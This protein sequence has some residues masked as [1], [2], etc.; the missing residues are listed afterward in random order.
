[1]IIYKAFRI[2]I[3]TIILFNFA[4]YSWSKSLKFV[5]WTTDITLNQD[6]TILVS[7]TLTGEFTGEFDYIRH[8]IPLENAKKIS[9]IKVYYE[10]GKQFEQDLV[11]IKYDNRKVRLRIKLYAK[12][13]KKRWTIEYKV[14]GNISFLKNYNQ[15]QWL[16]IPQDSTFT[17]EKVTAMVSLP[18]KVDKNK[19]DPELKFRKGIKNFRFVD[20][21][22]IE[23]WGEN[24]VPYE[25]F[26][27]IL[28]FP[29]GI[30]H[31]DRLPAILPFLWFMI[32]LFAFATQFIKWW[33]V[34]RNPIKR[35]PVIF[36]NEPSDDISPAEIAVLMGKDLKYKYISSTIVDLAQ[37]GYINVM[38]REKMT[39]SHIY[40]D[41][42]L[43]KNK[44]IDNSLKNHEIIILSAIFC[45][46]EN[47]I[48]SDVK[49]KINSIKSAV[50][51]AIV[52]Q[53]VKYEYL[54]I[55]PNKFRKI[56]RNISLFMF[57]FGAFLLPLSKFAIISFGLAGLI[58]VL[59]S[60]YISVKTLK[61]IDA[62]WRSAG[63]TKF[64]KF[65][66]RFHLRYVG[67][68]LF[69]EYLSYAIA[70]G[71]EREWANRFADIYNE[72]PKWYTPLDEFNIDTIIRFINALEIELV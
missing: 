41:Y 8:N 24:I 36:R 16:V 4:S 38:E 49:D 67:T 32:P 44:T 39:V 31:K 29:K 7:E 65:N 18:L 55:D 71:I 11:E 35:R 22:T 3:L 6:S 26:T 48:L 45:S 62:E 2:F 40:L 72:P 53:L 37:R 27:I 20:D 58:I 66:E 25:S 52:D 69:D 28:R 15:L 43:Q 57:L 60:R 19:L 70:L 47:V 17:V 42:R 61:G 68:R 64:L 13:E 54:T 14:Y 21:K 1:M 9:D 5:E 51:K 63:F 50:Y 56:Q 23:Y 46:Q 12:D 10:N 59:Y 33:E 30:L 34:Q